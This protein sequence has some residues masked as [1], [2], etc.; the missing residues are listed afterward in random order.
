MNAEEFSERLWDFAVRV[1]PRVNADVI[2]SIRYFCHAF[3]CTDEMR[4][5]VW[6]L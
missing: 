4:E 6:G 2:H 5:H 1:A 3:Q